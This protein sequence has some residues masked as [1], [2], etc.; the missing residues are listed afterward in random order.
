MIMGFGQYTLLIK[1]KINI[2]ITVLLFMLEPGHFALVVAR[3]YA[4]K[5]MC[6][7]YIVILTESK[8]K[9]SLYEIALVQ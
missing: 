9:M 6:Y 5:L 2:L 8:C 3:K 7:C 1:K 4:K